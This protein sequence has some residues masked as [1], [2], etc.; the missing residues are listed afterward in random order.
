MTAFPIRFRRAASFAL[1]TMLTS[2][3][4]AACGPA[5]VGTI[6][7]ATATLTQLR[8]ALEARTVTSERLVS[9]YLAR[10]ANCDAR[11]HAIIATNP[12]ALRAA[13]A[14]DA[15][16]AAGKPGGPLHGLP[17]ILK[18]NVDLAGMPTTAGSLA[19]AANLRERSAPLVDRLQAAGMVVIAKANLSEWA[20]FRSNDSS[21]GW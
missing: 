17:V 15:E 5:K 2:Q 13:R 19:L 16:R 3:C 20:N 21:S 14:L 7:L 9:A 10:I 4:F 6:D 18:D 11:L 1:L 12:D 8:S